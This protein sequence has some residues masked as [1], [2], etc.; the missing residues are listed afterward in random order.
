VPKFLHTTIESLRE[1]F[2]SDP[3]TVENA[4][5]TPIF[6]ATEPEGAASRSAEIMRLGQ[7]TIAHRI[8]KSA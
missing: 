2:A 8:A 3:E 1:A 7:E 4:M 5:A 6:P